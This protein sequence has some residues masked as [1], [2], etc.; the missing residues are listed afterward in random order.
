MAIEVKCGL[1]VCSSMDR[2]LPSEGRG[3]WFDPS[4]THHPL[5]PPP[6]S[7]FS[8]SFPDAIFTHPIFIYPGKHHLPLHVFAH[9]HCTRK[10]PVANEEI[11]VTMAY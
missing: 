2:V 7:R 10:K 1:R 4:Q 8:A 11:L 5:V 6:S 3:C 9:P